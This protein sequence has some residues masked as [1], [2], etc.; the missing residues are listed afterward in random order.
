MSGIADYPAFALSALA[1]LMLPGPG[2]LAILAAAAPGGHAALAGLMLGDWLL[3]TAAMIGAAALLLAHPWLFG[4]AQYLGVAYL[5]WVGSRLFL[6]RGGAPSA[7]P[8]RVI[9]PSFPTRLSDQRS[10][11]QGDHLLHGLLG[12]VHRPGAMRGRDNAGGNGRDDRPVLT[13]LYGALLVWG[14]R[15]LRENRRVARRLSRA[16]GAALS[17]LGTRL[18][19]D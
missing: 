12:A 1:F 11:P 19:T 17:G 10:Q 3:M 18:A 6:A 16:A 4:S 7:A 9:A 5:R 15:R 2:A 13:L 8:V 14:G